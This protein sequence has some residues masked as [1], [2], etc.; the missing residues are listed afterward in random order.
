M[1]NGIHFEI[2]T[3][4]PFAGR[5]YAKGKVNEKECVKTDYVQQKTTNA[6]VDLQ[7]GTCGMKGVRTVRT[8]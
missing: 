5:I 4:K 1:E 6:S 7:F 3:Q 8:V 2:K